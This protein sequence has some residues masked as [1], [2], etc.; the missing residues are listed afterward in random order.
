VC[1][2]PFSAAHFRFTT[3]QIV[4]NCALKYALLA[5]DHGALA[6]TT[7][8]TASIPSAFCSVVWIKHV[9]F[10]FLIPAAIAQ[11]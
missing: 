5:T 11:L 3:A 1:K 2:L 9:W 8:T 6:E 4:I 10:I 7:K